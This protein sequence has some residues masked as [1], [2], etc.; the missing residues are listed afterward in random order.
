[1]QSALTWFN[2]D[3]CFACTLAIGIAVHCDGCVACHKDGLSAW[4]QP[5]R[6]RRDSRPRDRRRCAEGTRCSLTLSFSAKAITQSGEQAAQLM[7]RKVDDERPSGCDA[8]KPMAIPGGR[9]VTVLLTEE[10]LRKIIEY[11]LPKED[12]ISDPVKLS[13][14]VRKSL[15]I[16]LGLPDLPWHDWDEWGKGLA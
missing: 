12:E 14:V 3:G 1:M 4:R 10:H 5:G 11:H 13:R 7:A 9:A 2:A 6:D 15:D 8:E 16:A